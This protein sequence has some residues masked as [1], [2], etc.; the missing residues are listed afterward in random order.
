M[1]ALCS[2]SATPSAMRWKPISATARILHGEAVAVGLGLAFRLSAR[3]GVCAA[4]DAARVV[5]HVAAIGLPAEL[6]HVEPAVLGR[7]G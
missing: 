4:A 6:S 7:R 5:A 1:A 3:L 2:T